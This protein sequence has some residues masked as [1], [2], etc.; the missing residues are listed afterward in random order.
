MSEATCITNG[1]T[2]DNE[3]VIDLTVGR[4]QEYLSDDTIDDKIT[5]EELGEIF[6]ASLAQHRYLDAPRSPLI[7][8][9]MVI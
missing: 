1:I 5:G 8:T 9:I 4:A 2:Y 6:Y 7:E 3:D